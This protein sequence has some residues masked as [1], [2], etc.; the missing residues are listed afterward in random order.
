[1]LGINVVLFKI[2][3]MKIINI[4]FIG[5]VFKQQLTTR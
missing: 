4:V 5:E 2:N 3:R 1:M